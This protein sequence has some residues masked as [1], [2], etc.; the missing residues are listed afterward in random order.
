MPY[1]VD[2]QLKAANNS[3]NNR[4]GDSRRT[5]YNTYNHRTVAFP[6]S[7]LNRSK[8]AKDLKDCHVGFEDKKP[9]F[10]IS[11]LKTNPSVKIAVSYTLFSSSIILLFFS[12]HRL[13]SIFFPSSSVISVYDFLRTS[14]WDL[15][16]PVEIPKIWSD[17]TTREYLLDE[18]QHRAKPRISGTIYISS[19]SLGLHQ[20]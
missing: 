17:D 12:L 1:A 7:F 10:Y 14:F 19:A 15:L 3:A 20:T 8:D 4:P 6:K 11:K 16:I 18:F 9:L 2:M 5:L 13:S